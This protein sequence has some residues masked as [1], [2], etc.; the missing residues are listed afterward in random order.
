MQHLVDDI[1]CNFP[2]HAA[3]KSLIRNHKRLF[4]EKIEAVDLAKVRRTFET[5][6][7]DNLRK[8]YAASLELKLRAIYFDRIDPTKVEGIV[9]I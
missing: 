1:F 8:K 3:I 4:P 5:L 7:K 2:D 6:R 9:R